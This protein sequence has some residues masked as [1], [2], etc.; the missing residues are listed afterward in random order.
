MTNI[1]LHYIKTRQ[2]KKMLTYLKC[3][4]INTEQ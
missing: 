4:Y 3:H 1:K 2:H